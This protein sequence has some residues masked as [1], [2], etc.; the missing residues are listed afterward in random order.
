[1]IKMQSI[2][3]IKDFYKNPIKFFGFLTILLSLVL[4]FGCHFHLPDFYTNRELANQI[5]NSVSARGVT[6]AVKHLLNPQYDIYN[7]IFQIWGWVLTLLIFSACF[8]VEKFKKFKELTVL[9]K[10]LFVYL[11]INISYL[12]WCYAYVSGYMIDLEKYVY[13]RGADSMG[14]PFF[15]M[16]GVLGF[17]GQIYYPI[18]N[19][20]AFVTFNTKIKRIFY[21]F[22]WGIIFLFW[23]V[24]ALDSFSWKFSYFHLIL[25]L[26][27]FISFVF[28]I[29][30]I[31]F[32]KNKKKIVI[33]QANDNEES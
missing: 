13:N 28:I 6:D 20:L 29:Y 32:T 17:I 5:A 14:I 24:I 33:N 3:K 22:L 30:A 18:M 11:W 8:R 27:Y 1:M 26:Y 15:G 23:A 16:I 19:L 21:N 25:D 31:G 12:I 10:K 2:D 9:N 4:L 7:W